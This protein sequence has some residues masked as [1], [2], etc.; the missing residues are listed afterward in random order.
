MRWRRKRM[1]VAEDGELIRGWWEAR[2]SGVV[3]RLPK[4]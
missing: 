1:K 4:G 3:H 2:G